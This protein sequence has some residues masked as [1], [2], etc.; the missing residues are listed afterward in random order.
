[1]EIRP[2]GPAD[3]PGIWPIWH[4]VVAAGDTYTWDPASGE[5]AGRV[6]WM[7]PPPAEVWVAVDGGT[8]VGTAQLRPNYPK[9]GAHIANASFMVASASAGRGIGRRLAEHLIARARETGYQA[10]QFNA[11][12]STNEHAVG[13]WKSLGFEII[14]TVP[15]G[16]Q[17][18]RL[19]YVDLY[20]MYRKLG[21]PAERGDGR[22]GQGDQAGG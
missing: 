11:V 3:W 10:M 8:I 16:F 15:D 2:A 18:A 5:E 4:E 19:G 1:M 9:L 14:G 21:P 13:L 22:P 12:V 20:V 6:A 7:L 17:H